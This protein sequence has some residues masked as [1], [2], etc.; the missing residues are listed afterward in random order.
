MHGK[1]L[2]RVPAAAMLTASALLTMAP[3]ASAGLTPEQQC[4]KGRYDAAAKYGQCHDKALGKLF[5]TN[6]LTTLQ[7]ALSK[8]RVKYTSTWLKLQTKAVGTGSTCDASRFVD[9][10]VGTVVDN[11]TGLEWE[12]KSDDGLYRDKDF[13]WSWIDAN[14]NFLAGNPNGGL[15]TECPGAEGICDWRL[16]TLAEL[17]TILSEPFPC[18]TSPCI[19]GV[20]GPTVV[21]D[22]WSSTTLADNPTYAWGVFFGTGEVSYGVKT[23]HNSVRAVRGGL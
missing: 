6:D 16:P 14:N 2:T 11:L 19:D 23:L 13:L 5:A 18:T 4:Q 17:Q 12:K 20:F 3:V 1:I 9:T 7:P 22:Y 21:H 15:N 8:C 10:G